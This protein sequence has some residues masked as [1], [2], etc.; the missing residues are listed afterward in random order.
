MEYH[1]PSLLSQTLPTSVNAHI[2]PESYSLQYIKVDHA[3]AILQDLGPGCFMSKL[4]IKSAFRNVPIHPSD[5][6]LLGM[7]WEGLYFFDMVLPFSL[8]SAHLLFDEFSS[9]VEWI[10][11]TTLNIPKVIHIL[12]DFFLATSPP[13]LKCMTAL[14]QILHLFTDLNIPIAPGRTFPA[15]TCLEFMGIL[16][17]SN[18]ME[19]RLQVDKLVCIQE[20]PGQWTTRK[21]ATLQELQSLIGTLQFASKVIAPGRPFLQ[22]IIHLLLWGDCVPCLCMLHNPWQGSATPGYTLT[23]SKA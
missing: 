20:A 10:I 7:K 4:D 15:Y 21:S 17:D 12:D 14:C 5:W 22:R 23:H 2:P 11:Q 16:L 19:A 8:R 3:I 6:E 9:A 18:K 13:R 1:N